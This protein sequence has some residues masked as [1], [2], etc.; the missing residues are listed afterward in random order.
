[1]FN[2]KISVLVSKYIFQTY[3][4][5]NLLVLMRRISNIHKGG[6]IIPAHIS[7]WFFC[8]YLVYFPV[9]LEFQSTNPHPKYQL[10]LSNN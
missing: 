7:F 10:K 8:T 1:M 3:I 6:L 4:L 9:F 2:S 5:T